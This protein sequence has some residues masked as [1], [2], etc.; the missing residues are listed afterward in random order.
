M[1]EVQGAWYTINKSE[2][3][4]TCLL[5]SVAIYLQQTTKKNLLKRKITN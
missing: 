4:F 3:I 1:C 2:D 5:T